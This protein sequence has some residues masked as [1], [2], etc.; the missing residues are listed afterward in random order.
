MHKIVELTVF[1][2][3]QARC[4]AI[5]RA[6]PSSRI[7]KELHLASIEAEEDYK[8]KQL[9]KAAVGSVGVAAAVGVAAGLATLLL[10]K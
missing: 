9:K 2:R 10:K 6:N 3:F 1:L 5:L 4:E 7:A 8:R